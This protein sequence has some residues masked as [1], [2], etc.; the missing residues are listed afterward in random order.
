MS[1]NAQLAVQN[2]YARCPIASPS[3]KYSNRA[4]SV[5]NPTAS[6]KIAV[7]PHSTIPTTNGIN[8]TAVAT[9]FQVIEMESPQ[10]SRPSSHHIMR[11]KSR[12][13]QA[14]GMRVKRAVACISEGDL[15]LVAQRNYGVLST[16]QN[17]LVGVECHLLRLAVQYEVDRPR[18]I[19]GN[20]H[21]A[22]P[23][24]SVSKIGENRHEHREIFVHFVLRDFRMHFEFA[25]FRR[26]H[27][28]LEI[29]P[30]HLRTPYPF[31]K[32]PIQ[33]P[34]LL[35]V[36]LLGHVLFG[37]RLEGL[38]GCGNIPVT[39]HEIVHHV[40]E[41]FHGTSPGYRSEG[42]RLNSSHITISYAVF[43]LKKKKI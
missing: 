8:T 2:R 39:F 15:Q 22:Q 26:L 18:G 23:H 31:S 16:L 19:P 40:D 30:G 17:F 34:I 3:V 42:T 37:D 20:G 36:H 29:V 41:R 27:V 24:H 13:K 25:A 10:R 32:K 1:S 11:N 38:R 5:T 21:L 35:Q 43:C 33:S 14:L 12:R 4:S 6:A 9:R 28:I 7:D